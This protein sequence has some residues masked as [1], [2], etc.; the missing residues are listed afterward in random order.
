M[1]PRRARPTT[2]ALRSGELGGIYAGPVGTE[3]GGVASR[4]AA[5][6]EFPAAVGTTVRPMSAPSHRRMALGDIEDNPQALAS[7]LAEDETLFVEHKTDIARGEAYQLAKASASFANTLGGWILVGVKNGKPVAGWEPPTGVFV[8]LVRQR[9]EGRLDPLPSFAARVLTHNDSRIGVIRVYES[10]DTPHILTADGSVV[11]REPAQDSKL[12]KA[13]HYDATPIRS[14][15]EL[16]QLTRRGA[17]ALRDAVERFEPGARPWIDH[18]LGTVPTLHAGAPA[19]ALRL[20]PLTLNGRWQDWAVSEAAVDQLAQL[21]G[22]LADGEAARDLLPH[23]RGV[24]VRAIRADEQ[25]WTPGGFMWVR[26]EAT[27]AAD[28]DGVFGVRLGYRLSQRS[29]K[30][31]Y[32][33]RLEKGKAAEELLAPMISGVV[34]LLGEVEFLGR[35]AAHLDWLR[36]NELFRIDPDNPEHGAPPPVLPVGGDLTIDGRASLAEHQRLTQRWTEELARSSGEAVWG[37]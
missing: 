9:L 19:L 8:D 37:S 17:E 27:V 35:F 3:C 15:H 2:R 23:A 31:H 33:R 5:R 26:Q 12:R 32:W 30:V 21:A 24:A 28:A 22:S 18:S 4:P 16:L 14:H 6:M 34:E 25:E 11:V 7:L 13:G 36:M 20:S 1:R 29:G 10:T